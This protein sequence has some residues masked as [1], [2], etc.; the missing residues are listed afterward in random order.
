M[1]MPNYP[2]RAY[3][4]LSFWL[5]AILDVFHLFLASWQWSPSSRSETFIWMTDYPMHRQ[6]KIRIWRQ[7]TWPSKY[8]F[9]QKKDITTKNML[10]F[11]G[12]L[13]S[14]RWNVMGIRSLW[15]KNSQRYKNPQNIIVMFQIAMAILP[16]D[17]DIHHV[18]KYLTSAIWHWSLQRLSHYKP[19]TPIIYPNTTLMEFNGNRLTV[20]G[21]T[22][23]TTLFLEPS[24]VP[25]EWMCKFLGIFKS[26]STSRRHGGEYKHIIGCWVRDCHCQIPLDGTLS[27]TWICPSEGSKLFPFLYTHICIYIY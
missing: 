1:L 4:F 22:I 3:H 25:W 23:N 12:I 8:E 13:A 26:F 7:V 10:V 16:V 9:N 20:M 24:M 15:Q 27:S 14:L 19:E 6:W 11:G 21:D 18:K 5:S 17:H 2:R